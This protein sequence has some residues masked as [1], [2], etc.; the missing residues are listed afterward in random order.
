[1]TS[2][3]KITCDGCSADLSDKG[4]TR[5]RHRLVLATEFI[6]VTN[7]SGYDPPPI[8]GRLHFCSIKCLDQWLTTGGPPSIE[9]AAGENLDGAQ[10]PP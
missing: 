8:D 6:L 9:P 10:K 7:V 4:P 2:H 1:M 5:L 3:E